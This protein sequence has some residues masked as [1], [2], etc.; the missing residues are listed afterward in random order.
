MT[1]GRGLALGVTAALVFVGC[2]RADTE[3][4][5]TT[6]EWTEEDL[7]RAREIGETIDLA[8]ESIGVERFD[9]VG[10]VIF[11]EEWRSG[12]KS[13]VLDVR[14][15]GCGPREIFGTAALVG[16]R[17]AVTA[18]HVIAGAQQVTVI[19]RHG[20]QHSVDVVLFDPDNDVAVLRT[21]ENVGEPLGFYDGD[22]DAGM[23]GKAAFAR[24]VEDEV[25][26]RTGDIEVLRHVEIETTDIYLDREVTRTGFEILATI[27]PG[28]SGAVVVI[29][30]G[31]AGVIWARSTEEP[32]RAWAVDIPADVR[33]PTTR[34][35]LVESVDVGDCTN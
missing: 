2:S 25:D 23:V 29:G 8:R 24:L 26:I 9:T 22:I 13:A 11:S 7:A 35:A 20:V 28:D 6:L 17:H 31:A 15:E 33:D 14:A 3:S 4:D 12:V 16:D 32:N 21:P 10:N 5:S 1:R 18:A 27:D 30:G 34:Q 19:D